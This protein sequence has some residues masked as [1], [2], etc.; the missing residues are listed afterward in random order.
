MI[1]HALLFPLLLSAPAAA[2][3][4]LA[5]YQGGAV[6]RAEYESWLAA[7]GLTHDAAGQ[8]KALEAIALAK[9]L[10]AGAR[11]AGLAASAATAFRLEQIETAALS[12][13]YW[14]QVDSEVTVGDAAVEAELKAEEKER[15]RPRSVL[16]RNLFKRVPPGA[17]PSE[18]EALRVRTEELRRQL[19]AGADFEELASRESDSQTRFRGGAM[20]YVRAGVLSPEVDRVVM[21]L[22]K[23]ELSAVLSSADGFTILR[24]DDIFEG[25]V[26]PVAEARETIR[27]GLRSRAVVARR[28]AVREELL[29]EAA[30]RYLDGVLDPESPVVEFQGGQVRLV[31]LQV[32]AG[33]AP[34]TLSAESRRSLLEEQVVRAA[35]AA[36]ARALRLHER[37]ELEA[38]VRWQRARLLATEEIARRINLGLTSPTAAEIRAHYERNRERY[39]TPLKVDVSLIEWAAEPTRLRAV[40]DAAE[41]VLSRVQSGAVTFEAAAREV[42]VHPTAAS[43]GRTGLLPMVELSVLG[44]N[45]FRTVERMSPGETSRLVQ[46][47]SRLFAV[48]LWERQAPRPMTYDEAAHGVEKELGD[49]RVAARQKELEAEA[50]RSL[51]LEIAA[52]PAPRK[53]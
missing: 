23:G 10:E 7:Q 41:A 49:A 6:T 16:L 45:L 18:R 22:G 37:P 17:S 20:G 48:K 1:L 46:Q 11:A 13:A 28:A 53:D 30:P 9:S 29:R 25:R 2:T 33:A 38:R 15:V 19:L 32:L 43:G 4:V 3:D 35:A 12:A 36:R 8:A 47:E 31:G 51:G 27:N 21:A 5:T 40:F 50:V 52:E 26:I 44:P 34:E 39:L 42:S 24:C 14:Q